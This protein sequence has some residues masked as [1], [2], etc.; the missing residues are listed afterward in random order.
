MDSDSLN[1]WA[2]GNLMEG[3]DQIDEEQQSRYSVK[4]NINMD[5]DEKKDL[6][7]LEQMEKL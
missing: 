6:N 1:T 4:W 5:L 7:E 3:H 2:K